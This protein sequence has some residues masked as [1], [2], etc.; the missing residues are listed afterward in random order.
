[1]AADRRTTIIEKAIK[2]FVAKGYHSTS[3]QEIAEAC[4]IAKG[5]LYNY[6]ESKEDVM[7][8]ILKYY[9]E[10]ILVET[11]KIA[12]DHSLSAKE[13]FIQQIYFQFKECV[14]HSDFIE[15]HIRKYAIH[16]NEE[17]NEFLF[18]L[19]ASRLRWLTKCLRN[20]YGE[21]IDL[22]VLDLATIMNGFMRE[23]LE[24]IILDKK[25]FDIFKLSQFI[26]NR[27]DDLVNGFMDSGEFFLEFSD[28]EDFMKM[29]NKSRVELNHK[30]SE[31]I[32]QVLRDLHEVNVSVEIANKVKATMEVFEEELI[33]KEEPKLVI[34]EGVLLFLKNLN[35]ASFEKYWHQLDEIF[36]E[37]R[38]T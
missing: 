10:K 18:E 6:F 29:N 32:H 23:Y 20:V 4:G 7:L 13:V 22:Y 25:D 17:I 34:A 26:M 19:K 37:Y 2:L 36:Y 3:M 12:K 33:N 11:E 15:M 24:Y 9:S 27:M 38:E 14:K 28:L 5:T 30:I 31:I 8:S 35:I 21:K 16:V 1:M